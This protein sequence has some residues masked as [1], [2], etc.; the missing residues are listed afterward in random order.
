MNNNAENAPKSLKHADLRARR[1][2]IKIFW[3]HYYTSARKLK[4]IESGLP[5]QFAKLGHSMKHYIEGPKLHD[6]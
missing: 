4:G 6:D 2:M 3:A 5:Y 1:K